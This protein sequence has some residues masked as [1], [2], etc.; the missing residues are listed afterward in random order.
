M[1]SD[2]IAQWPAVGPVTDVI[3][4]AIR[5]A[6]IYSVGHSVGGAMALFHHIEQDGPNSQNKYLYTFGS[7]CMWHTSALQGP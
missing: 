3:D 6:R 4:G 1:A 2:R 7:Q 5:C